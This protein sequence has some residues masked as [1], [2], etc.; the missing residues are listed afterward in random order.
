MNVFKR[1]YRFLGKDMEFL[2]KYWIG[3]VFSASA[4][5]ISIIIAINLILELDF[6]S[7][8]IQLISF[9]AII[10]AIIGGISS[11]FFMDAIKKKYNAIGILVLANFS[12][13]TIIFFNLIPFAIVSILYIFLSYSCTTIFINFCVILYQTTGILERGRVISGIL[14]FIILLLP[15]LYLSLNFFEFNYILTAVL[16]LFVAYIFYTKRHQELFLTPK[17]TKKDL[18]NEKTVKYLIILSGLGFIEGLIHP[19]RLFNIDFDFFDVNFAFI[20]SPIILIISFI[21]VGIIFDLYGRRRSIALMVFLVGC[22]GFLSYFDKNP[23]IANVSI[24]IYIAV[25]IMN[26]IA[27]LTIIGDIAVSPAKIIPVISIFIIGSIFGGIQVKNLLQDSSG[28]DLAPLFLGNFGLLIIAMVLINT[29]D[30]LS[31]KEQEWNKHL[32]S[33]FV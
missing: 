13:F 2:R 30:T 31:Q 10:G 20:I 26:L 25:L 4:I 33:I 27:L 28:F 29:T 9:Y 6:D 17:V 7:Y 1:L 18:I 32:V 12:C 16:A 15:M 23:I 22:Y 24:G 8:Q 14:A 19:T 21:L 5:G 11:F 3:S